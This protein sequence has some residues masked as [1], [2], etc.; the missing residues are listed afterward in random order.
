M[1][2]TSTRSKWVFAVN[3]AM[4]VTSIPDSLRMVFALRALNITLSKRGASRGERIS[5]RICATCSASAEPV[6]LDSMQPSIASRPRRNVFLVI[7]QHRVDV[8][9][10][11]RQHDGRGL[12]GR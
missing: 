12:Q 7:D 3:G 5:A 11:P 4:F 10:D 1:P 6:R 8:V 9:F 2:G